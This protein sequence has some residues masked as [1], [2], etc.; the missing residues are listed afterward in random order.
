MTTPIVLGKSVK[1]LDR[2]IAFGN[3]GV[4][5]MRECRAP[6]YHNIAGIL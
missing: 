3:H 1:R 5:I 2:E 6:K 4:R